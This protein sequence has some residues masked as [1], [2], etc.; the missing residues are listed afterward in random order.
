M[1]GFEPMAYKDPKA[2]ALPTTPQRHTNSDFWNFTQFLS[3]TYNIMNDIFSYRR[4]F[5]S[6]ITCYVLRCLNGKNRS[7][8][9]VAKSV[10]CLVAAVDQFAIS[11]LHDVTCWQW[12]LHDL[13]SMPYQ[14]MDRTNQLVLQ[15]QSSRVSPV[16]FRS[17]RWRFAFHAL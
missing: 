14:E 5:P 16:V 10:C 13:D 11:C 12:N 6:C 1:L 4:L 7:V 9:Y 3:T 17:S 8:N 15:P 2:S